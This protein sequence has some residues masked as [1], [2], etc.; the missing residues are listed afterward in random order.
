[1][2]NNSICFV[3]EPVDRDLFPVGYGLTSYYNTDAV[4][5]SAIL[6]SRSDIDHVLEVKPYYQLKTTGYFSRYASV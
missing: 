6:D 4:S 1:M 5:D 3:F 2:T